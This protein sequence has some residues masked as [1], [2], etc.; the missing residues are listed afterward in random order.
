MSDPVHKNSNV[1]NKGVF[2]KQK[3]LVQARILDNKGTYP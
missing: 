3:G 1:L 2:F